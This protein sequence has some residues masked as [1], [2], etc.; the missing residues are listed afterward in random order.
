MFQNV[1]E[2]FPDGQNCFQNVSG[3]AGNMLEATLA[4]RK[5]FG[6]V[7]ETFCKLTTVRPLGQNSVHNATRTLR[8]TFCNVS[9]PPLVEDYNCEFQAPTLYTVNDLVSPRPIS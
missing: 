1:S 3:G 6:S 7:L 5:R 8:R 9:V 2:T 4:V